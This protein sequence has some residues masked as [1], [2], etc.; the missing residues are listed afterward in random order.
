M[1]TGHIVKIFSGILRNY[2]A[3]S[4]RFYGQYDRRRKVRDENELIV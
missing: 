1:A 2:I 4:G 3:R